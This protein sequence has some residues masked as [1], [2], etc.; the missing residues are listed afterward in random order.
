MQSKLIVQFARLSEAQFQ[1]KADVI[2]GSL[3]AHPR[4]PEPWPAPA[5]TT[6]TLSTAL[7]NYRR[8][9]RDCGTR[10]ILKIDQRNVAREGL[11]EMLKKLAQYL[12][13]IA[14][15]DMGMLTT[16]GFDLRREN[17]RP[18]T[19]KLPA[20]EGLKLL[21]GENGGSID[22]RIRRLSGA[23]SYEVQV[24]QGDPMLDASWKHVLTSTAST[25]I[26]L[27]DL[28]PK[29]T[30]WVRVRGVSSNG[31]GRWSEPVSIFVL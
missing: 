26:T 3:T 9:V 8:A 4:F 2:I 28:P 30:L 19:D 25:G 1:A 14:Q 11:T 18:S 24:T 23:G 5:P 21:H 16:T 17:S 15:G 12:E 27:N 6:A 7:E 29:Q 13:F 31:G 10:D 20:P 22:V